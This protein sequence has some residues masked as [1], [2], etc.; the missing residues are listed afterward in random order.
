[1]KLT[2]NE[3]I[4]LIGGYLNEQSV[5][6]GLED[7]ESNNPNSDKEQID[8]SGVKSK[9]EFEVKTRSGT[10]DIALIKS[11]ND[12]NHKIYVDGKVRE[13]INSLLDMNIISAHGYLN[14]DK[15]DI[16]KILLKIL[17][18]DSDFKGKGEAGVKA[19][20]A[21]KIDT[22]GVQ[23]YSQSNLEDILGKG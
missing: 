9:I 16:K 12:N 18:R 20:I 23:S 4:K 19:V 14:T 8:K 21:Q 10:K 11:E 3:L 22:R 13:D 6:D 2:K 5:M 17:Q 1:M 7:E 15:D